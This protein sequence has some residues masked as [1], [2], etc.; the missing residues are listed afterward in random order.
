MENVKT[1][2]DGAVQLPVTHSPL[3]TSHKRI[4]TQEIARSL[5]SKI[6]HLE[7]SPEGLQTSLRWK[8]LPRLNGPQTSSFDD[9]NPNSTK[10]L[11]SRK[12]SNP[13]GFSPKAHEGCVSLLDLP[14][15]ILILIFH[16][17]PLRVI[18][19]VSLTCHTFYRIASDNTI[20][21]P[22]FKRRHGKFARVSKRQELKAPG[23]IKR[24]YAN[25]SRF[26]A[27]Q[28]AEVSAV[29]QDSLFRFPNRCT[30]VV[31]G[32]QMETQFFYYCKTCAIIS[33]H[34]TSLGGNITESNG[35]CEAC[36]RICHKGHDVIKLSHNPCLSYCDC[37]EGKL[38]YFLPNRRCLCILSPGIVGSAGQT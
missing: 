25:Y 4:K 9:S 22:F 21:F 30:F 35:C 8:T 10:L 23:G 24:L 17:L 3:E 34:V 32:T 19:L 28:T 5:L 33:S 27:T 13:T 37:G 18:C 12:I 36:A 38:S 16:F 31:T 11:E 26:L 7:S 15:D 29:V 14:E 20:W 1:S 6:D 2:N